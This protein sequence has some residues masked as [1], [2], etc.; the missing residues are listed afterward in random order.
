G[1]RKIMFARA[2]EITSKFTHPV[3]ASM[4]FFD[5][6]VECLLGAFTII[7]KDCWALSAAHLLEPAFAF[8]KHQEEIN[9]YAQKLSLID[10]DTNLSATHKLEMKALL[11]INP[12]WITNYSYWWG[13]DGV[14]DKQVHVLADADL[15][16]V[17]LENFNMGGITKFP[18]IKNPA[19]L[20]SGTSLCK[21]GFPFHQAQATFDD[22]TKSF[23]LLPETL[24]VPLFPMEGIFTRW[25]RKGF[26][27][28]NKY[29]IK[30]I[31]TSSSGL[32]GQSGG[33]IFDING[34][35][36]GIQIQTASIPLGYAPKV[37]IDGKDTVEHQFINL[38]LGIH[39]ELIVAFLKDNN[40][41]FVLSDE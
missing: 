21:L 23:T 17:Q 35:I 40:I 37:T 24:P 22:K 33:P 32:R 36:W 12:K 5:G 14:K 38:G 9:D 16:V 39:P 2:Y 11:S 26:S 27:E 18:V 6:T 15:V 19:N 31:E 4:K 20:K 13:Q 29:D 30:Y 1:V 34:T 7:N 3:I 41:G 25:I 8:Q 28:N 10:E